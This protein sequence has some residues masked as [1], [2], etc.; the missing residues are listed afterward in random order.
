M[1]NFVELAYNLL[2]F[3][4]S[5]NVGHLRVFI[6]SVYTAIIIVIRKNPYSCSS[7]NFSRSYIKYS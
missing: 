7:L 3:L 4:L 2:I 6:I 5:C 1:S